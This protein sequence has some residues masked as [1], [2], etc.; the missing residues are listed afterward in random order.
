MARISTKLTELLD[1]EH[2][3]LL[4]PMNLV[5]GGRLAAAV[6]AAGG[7]GIIGGG[8]GDGTWL[9]EQFQAAGNQPVGVGFITWSLARQPELFDRVLA[10][11]PRAVMLSFGDS[12]DYVARAREAGATTLWQ[13]QC[14]DQA[15]QALAAGTDILVVQGQ[16][17]GGH[18]M[19]R[20]LMSLLP[21]VRDLAGPDAALVAAGGIA[22]GRGLA[23]ALMLGADGV[24]MGTRF[25]ASAE[26]NG[27]DADKAQVA[28]ARGDD[29]VRTSVFDLARG[30]DWPR[31]FTVRT[32]HNAFSK[33][34]HGDLSG[35]ERD[36]DAQRAAYD[37]AVAADDYDVKAV[38]VGESVDLIDSVK[39]AADIVTET[40]SE[41]AELL[42]AQG[43]ATVG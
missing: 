14:L 30:F 22:D 4:A 28:G 15:R 29:T 18:G 41:A 17:A 8:Y 13:V 1:I 34:W 26:A 35:L 39:H 31:H 23:A 12:E 20:G 33:R 6:T 42:R 2:P 10:H 38:I 36:L 16:E 43:R 3:V 19:D 32:V 24:L 9:D 11:G 5:S 27:S 25:W 40:V 37:A 7:F 21:A